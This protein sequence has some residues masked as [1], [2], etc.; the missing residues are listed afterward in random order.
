MSI[1]Y[2]KIVRYLNVAP[3]DFVSKCVSWI[4]TS[5]FW[6]LR[7]FIQPSSLE[8]LEKQSAAIENKKNVYDLRKL[9]PP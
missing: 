4:S 7:L 1:K 8:L 6:T 9:V 5:G 2:S 3:R